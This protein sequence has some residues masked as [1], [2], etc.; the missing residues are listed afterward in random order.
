MLIVHGYGFTI[1][2]VTPRTDATMHLF[3]LKGVKILVALHS[4]DK[5]LLQVQWT[6]V[7]HYTVGVEL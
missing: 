3:P 5:F 4:N 2:N 7:M 6:P 1:I